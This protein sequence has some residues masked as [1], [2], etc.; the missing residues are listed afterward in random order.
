MSTT[1]G[2]DED[3]EN[4]LMLMLMLMLMPVPVHGRVHPPLWSVG[5]PRSRRGERRDGYMHARS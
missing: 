2:Q 4:M 3:G 5:S 1:G